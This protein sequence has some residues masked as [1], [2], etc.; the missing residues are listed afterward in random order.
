MV[1]DKATA[2]LLQRLLRDNLEERNRLRV[3]REQLL[4]SQLTD[5]STRAALQ[6]PTPPPRLPDPTAVTRSDSVLSNA[7]LS[8]SHSSASIATPEDGMSTPPSQVSTPS[9]QC[10][11]RPRKSLS[12]STARSY[13]NGDRLTDDMLWE[14]ES[15]TPQQQ[16]RQ[17]RKDIL[18]PILEFFDPLLA[19]RK[20][21]LFIFEKKKTPNPDG[22]FSMRKNETLNLRMWTKLIRKALQKIMGP[23]YL[24]NHTLTSRFRFAAKKIVTKRRANHVQNWRLFQASKKMIYSN[25]QLGRSSSSDSTPPAGGAGSASRLCKRIKFEKKPSRKFH[26][27]VAHDGQDSG[28]NSDATLYY[29]DGGEDNGCDAGEDSCDTMPYEDVDEGYEDVDE[30]EKDE[31]AGIVAFKKKP[32]VSMKTHKTKCSVCSKPLECRSAFPQDH[33]DWATSVTRPMRCVECWNSHVQKTLM[34]DLQEKIKQKSLKKKTDPPT[35]KKRKQCKCG[36]TDHS[37]TTSLNC[38]LN[39]RNL[40]EPAK[41]KRKKTAGDKKKKSVKPAGKKKSKKGDKPA[42]AAA[43]KKSDF[44]ECL[45]DMDCQGIGGYLETTP[46]DVSKDPPAPTNDPPAP[47]NDPPVPTNDPPAQ[48]HDI[49]ANVKAKFQAKKNQSYLAHVIAY[50][51]GKY[52]VYFVE[53]GDVKHGLTHKDI[54]AYDGNYATRGEMINRDFFD[55]GD[56]EFPAGT[57]RVRQIVDNEF[58]CIR[59][60]GGDMLRKGELVNFDIGYVITTYQKQLQ[61]Q[62][63]QGFGHVLQSR[64]RGGSHV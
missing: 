12:L 37:M 57:F 10:P 15:L 52:S 4:R 59:I 34:P 25:P 5:A 26:V 2:E 29:D 41:K 58:K 46:P 47:T 20:S 53:G 6:T 17:D 23:A 18:R 7:S 51:E 19:P 11:P 38:P 49:G 27:P 33:E 40:V 45:E 1:M 54:R 62:R 42:A 44:F 39:K 63:E 50:N 16:L 56:E 35:K 8:R 3:Q 22:T 61:N 55:E 30:G 64:T 32:P 13:T 28:Y 48:Q 60:T 14:D 21:P 43:A 31:D 24:N 36:S 9:D